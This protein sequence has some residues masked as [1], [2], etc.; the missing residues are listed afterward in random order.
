[1]TTCA[2]CRQPFAAPPS[3][4]RRFCSGRCYRAFQAAARAKPCAACGTVF[5]AGKNTGRQ[6]ACSPECGAALRV[7]REKRVCPECGNPFEAKRKALTKYCSPFCRSKV[8][9][10]AH[11]RRGIVISKERWGHGPGRSKLAAFEASPDCKSL[12]QPYLAR[13]SLDELDACWVA[14]VVEQFA[15]DG[16]AGMLSHCLATIRRAYRQRME[17]LARPGSA[18]VSA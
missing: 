16:E 9:A 2:H 15:R 8:L 5:D 3:K 7:K 6:R 13:R 12:V 11:E 1:M 4:Q 17:A 14:L 10:R 18:T